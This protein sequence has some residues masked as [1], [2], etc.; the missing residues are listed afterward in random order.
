MNYPLVMHHDMTHIQA[1]WSPLHSASA[2][3]HPSIVELLIKSGAQLGMQTKVASYVVT[4]IF[5]SWWLCNCAAFYSLVP[6]HTQ[7]VCMHRDHARMPWQTRVLTFW[8]QHSP[9]V[10]FNTASLYADRKN[11]TGLGRPWGRQA[12]CPCPTQCRG[13]PWYSGWGSL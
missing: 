11:G 12:N 1:G 2:Y 8:C 6:M 13:Q 7:A 10:E 5:G 9:K 3:C 4:L